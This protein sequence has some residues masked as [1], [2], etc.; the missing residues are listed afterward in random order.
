MRVR[1][2]A[3][4]APVPLPSKLAPPE[5]CLAL[6]NQAA[7][8]IARGL[9]AKGAGPDWQSIA[10]IWKPSFRRL[11]DGELAELLPRLAD[12]LPRDPRGRVVGGWS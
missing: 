10:R 5:L 4:P 11:S 6:H 2:T 8:I 3:L 9:N 1:A 7:R 12:P